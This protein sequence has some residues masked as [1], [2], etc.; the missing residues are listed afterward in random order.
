LAIKA[1]RLSIARHW[2]KLRR[3]KPAPRGLGE[4]RKQDTAEAQEIM[5]AM[6]AAG[7]R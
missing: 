1:L 2:Q 3:T 7:R 6:N 4:Y 5:I